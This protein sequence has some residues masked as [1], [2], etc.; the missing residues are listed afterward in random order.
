MRK[1]RGFAPETMGEQ[2]GMQETGCSLVEIKIKRKE[3][4]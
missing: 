3:K 1:H 2:S 4:L